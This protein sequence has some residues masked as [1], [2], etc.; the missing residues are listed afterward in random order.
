MAKGQSEDRG[1]RRNGRLALALVGVFF[2]MVGVSFAAVPLYD[3]FCRVTGIAGTTQVSDAAPGV[4]GEETITI[5]FNADVNQ[6]LPWQFEPERRSM[7]VRIGEPNLVHYHAK[8]LASRPTVGTAVY[9]VSPFKAGSY[10][11]KVQCF[12]FDEQKLEGGEE[13]AMGVSFYVDPA[14]LDDPRFRDMHTITLSYTFFRDLD[15]WEAEQ[16]EQQLSETAPAVSGY[17]QEQR[18]AR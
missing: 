18:A 10:F 11:H 6:R 15:D 9:N 7:E 1:A 8:N 4:V 17:R 12:C 5:R 16:E 13:M 3:L 2:A 14:I